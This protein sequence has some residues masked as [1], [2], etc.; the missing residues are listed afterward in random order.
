MGAEGDA[1][2]VVPFGGV[3]CAGSGMV[4][5][6]LRDEVVYQEHG[7]SSGLVGSA[8]AEIL[9]ILKTLAQSVIFRLRHPLQQGLQMLPCR[10]LPERLEVRHLLQGG[11]V[12]QR[13]GR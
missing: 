13:G 4:L 11:V 1:P 12:G 6:C 3:G 9:F 5:L 10:L 8:G 7:A 2:S